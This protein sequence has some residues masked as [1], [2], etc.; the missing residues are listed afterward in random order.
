MKKHLSILLILTLTVVTNLKTQNLTIDQLITLRSKSLGDIEEFLTARKWEFYHALDPSDT[1]MGSA[2][3]K[4]KKLNSNLY[5]DYLYHLNRN[6]AIQYS[7][8]QIK[9][10]L[11]EYNILISRI[12]LLGYKLQNSDVLNGS[13][14]KIYR[15]GDNSIKITITKEYLGNYMNSYY[16]TYKFLFEKQSSN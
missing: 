16:S 13:I 11:T 7:I 14:I 10:D 9:E 5:I 8:E 3:F 12:K 6:N 2:M 1:S 15:L 4:F